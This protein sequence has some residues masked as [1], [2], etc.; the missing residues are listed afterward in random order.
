[1]AEAA[2]EAVGLEEAGSAPQAAE[3]W[4]AAGWAEAVAGGEEEVQVEVAK[5]SAVTG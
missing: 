2:T 4:A 5:A 3:G 1:M